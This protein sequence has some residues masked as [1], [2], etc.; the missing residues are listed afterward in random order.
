MY[1]ALNRLG[2]RC[3]HMY[4]S[5]MNYRHRHMCC[6]LEAINFKVN[7]VGEPYYPEDFDKILQEYS[8]G[9]INILGL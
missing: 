8:V 5:S 2:Y 9:L 3:Y 4:E 1:T 6:W 7:G